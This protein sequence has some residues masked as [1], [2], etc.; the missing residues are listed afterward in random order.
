ML[1][2]EPYELGMRSTFLT[3][4]ISV[5]ER[6]G[7]LVRLAEQDRVGW[8]DVC[9]MPGWSQHSLEELSGELRLA[10]D[11]LRVDLV[12]DV[13]DTLDAFPE[14]RAGLAGAVADL[15]AQQAGVALCRHLN[16][17]ASLSVP[18]H[19]TVTE[20]IAANIWGPA[21][22]AVIE[23]ITTLKIK[24]GGRDLSQDIDRVAAV[25][26]A[27]GPAI[28]IRLDANGGWDSRTAHRALDALATF[29]IEF[30]EEPVSGIEEIAR[31]AASSPISLAVDESAR[32]LDGVQAALDHETIKV[33]VIKPQAIG[34][35]DLAMR[36]CR[37]IEAADATPVIT[38]MV[39]S[40]V[41]VAQAAHV[42]AAAATTVAH[43]LATSS[44]IFRDV[45]S[46]LKVENGRIEI[47]DIPGLGVSPG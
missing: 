10:A 23:G 16:P 9:P 39:D 12:P 11:R 29:D 46:P 31:V 26:E 28:A 44:M 35:P 24:V 41:G 32:S 42:A 15:F 3:S 38:S 21:L 33:F 45:A 8:G 40:A 22:A 17:D 13:L 37:L 18:V 20:P 14:A 43:G 25:R 47:P 2:L 6:R 36:A 30:C 27:V 34:G 7:T 5:R 4:A 1:K 19:S